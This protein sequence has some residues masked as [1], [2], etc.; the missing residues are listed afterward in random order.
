MIFTFFG[1]VSVTALPDISGE[2][3]GMKWNTKD[4]ITRD[5]AIIGGGASGTYAAIRLG[6]L[7]Q[8]VVLIERKDRLGGH[9]ET[10]TDP[11]TG[12]NIELG[13]LEYHNISLV[14]NFFARFNIPLT[15]ASESSPP[16][17]I[18]DVVDFRTGKIVTGYTPS[19]PTAALGVYASQVAQYPYLETGFDLP[20]PVPA[21]LL[22]PFG[23]F[24]TKYN[25]SAAANLIFEFN[26][27]AGDFLKVPTIYIMKLLALSVLQGIQT[28][29]LTTAN[30]DNSQLYEKAEA[31][32]AAAN[33]VLLSSHVMACERDNTG[34][35]IAVLTPSGPKLILAKKV[36]ITM[37]PTLPNMQPFELDNTEL[38]IFRQFSASGYY[39]GLIRNSGIPD[40]IDF[41]NIGSNTPFNLPA[42]PGLYSIDPT[43][44]PGLHQFLYGSP[45]VLSNEQVKNNVLASVKELRSAG[46]L[47]TT[48]PEFVVFS[49]HSPFLM[50][51]PSE[52]IKNG[53][54]RNLTGL[55]GHRST[56]Y[57]GATFHT[58]D[59][60]LLWQ[61]TEAL[62][63]KL[64]A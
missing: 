10:Y 55:Q 61:F 57:T 27:G 64:V 23:D 1:A 53:F 7:N 5:I 3:L 33:A 63:P 62:L 19:D 59:S 34:V 60:S 24:I 37:P 49:S 26:Q 47:N 35:K 6:D 41:Q 8:S 15:L 52:A 45:T 25:I 42:L 14:T 43:G 58:H 31:V 17:L 13:V 11:A 2:T 32:L 18:Q 51:V 44:V 48:T 29:F 12:I 30:H 20:D 56:Y 54:Y 50:T 28:G 38:G 39:T 22:L 4:V 16:G 21:D 46:T 36:L 40:N 9:T